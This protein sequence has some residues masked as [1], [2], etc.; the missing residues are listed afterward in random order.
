MN[1]HFPIEGIYFLNE[2]ITIDGQKY[3]ADLLNRDCLTLLEQIKLSNLRI[4]ELQNMS[5]L[6]TRAKNAY[7]QDISEEI[8]KDKSG[9]DLGQIF[10]D[11]DC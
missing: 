3:Q 5:A 6:L 10:S 7:I 11:D 1:I 4:K 2:T 9:I 8:V